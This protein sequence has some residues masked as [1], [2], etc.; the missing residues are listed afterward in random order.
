[1]SDSSPH[2]VSKKREFTVEVLLFVNA[3]DKVEAEIIGKAIASY[4]RKEARGIYG[5]AVSDVRGDDDD[6]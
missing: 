3:K 2:D 4:A 5:A 6:E 1:M